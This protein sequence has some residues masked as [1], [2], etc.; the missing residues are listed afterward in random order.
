VNTLVGAVGGPL[1]VS[2]LTEHVFGDLKLVG[3]SIAA[4]VVPSLLAASLL[5]AAARRAVRREVA[6]GTAPPP[7]LQEL[8][9]DDS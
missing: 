7:L 5:Y 9:S 2:L 4:V 1:L 8:A 6:Q 3:W